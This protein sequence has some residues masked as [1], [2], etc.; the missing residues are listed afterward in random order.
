MALPSSQ[1]QQPHRLNRQFR[2]LGYWF[3]FQISERALPPLNLD[4]SG[5]KSHLNTPDHLVSI[6]LRMSCPSGDLTAH[7]WLGVML[8]DSD[9][10][11]LDLLK[12]VAQVFLSRKVAKNRCIPQHGEKIPEV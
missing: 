2:I 10:V 3:S 12:C 1:L 11:S 8:L 7:L 9:T 5:I 4:D 6:Q